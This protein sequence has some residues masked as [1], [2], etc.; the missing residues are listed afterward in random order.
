MKFGVQVVN[1]PKESGLE[2]LESNSNNSD[3]WQWYPAGKEGGQIVQPY[4]S[5]YF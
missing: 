3:T 4:I 5:F 1:V 2:F